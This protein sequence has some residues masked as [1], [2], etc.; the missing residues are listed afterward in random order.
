MVKE[1]GVFSVT[2]WIDSF[3][4]WGKWSFMGY[5]NLLGI[6]TLEKKL[7]LKEFCASSVLCKE[8]KNVGLPHYW[9]ERSIF[10]FFFV[11]KK[12]KTRLLLGGGSVFSWIICHHWNGYVFCQVSID[13]AAIF[14]LWHIHGANIWVKVN[15]EYIVIRVCCHVLFAKMVSSWLVESWL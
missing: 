6:S 8:Q 15:F 7:L 4:V 12:S 2:V 9:W 13:Y 1:K 3:S 10:F 14:Y 11:V 5:R